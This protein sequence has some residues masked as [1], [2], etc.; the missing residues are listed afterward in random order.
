MSK[1]R[2]EE[3]DAALLLAAI[4]LIRGDEY[5]HGRFRARTFR[6]LHDECDANMYPAGAAE[7]VE[8]EWDATDQASLDVLTRLADRIDF[9]LQHRPEGVL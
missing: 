1:Q 6:D 2:P 8:F 5:E 7:E 9:W 3:L 4:R